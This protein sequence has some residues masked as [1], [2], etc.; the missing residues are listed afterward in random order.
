LFETLGFTHL[1]HVCSVN[2]R[3]RI[4]KS[5]GAVFCTCGG[6]LH[7]LGNRKGPQ[8]TLISPIRISVICVNLRTI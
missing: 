8:I 6:W 5:P 1:F 4:V 3:L 7:C 2:Y